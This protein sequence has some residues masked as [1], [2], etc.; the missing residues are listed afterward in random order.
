MLDLIFIFGAK[1]L[2]I[3]PVLLTTYYYFRSSAEIRKRLL[4]FLVLIL[5]FTYIL[6]LGARSLY[7]NPRPFVTGGYAPLIPHAADNGFPSD[8]ILLA[9]SLA[10]AML[11]F[12]R[13]QASWLWTL[14][15]FIALSRVYAGV[16]HA[17]DV[18]ASMGLA[19]LCA[20]IIAKFYARK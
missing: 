13:K 10:A 5:P 18:A 16:H 2:I 6:G 14:T 4:I 8:H 12:D 17:L 15:A 3:V 1:Y 19:F 7:Y 9:A 11:F 20:I